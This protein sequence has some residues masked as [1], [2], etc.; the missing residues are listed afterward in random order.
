[1]KCNMNLA[2]VSAFIHMQEQI[3][4][5][6]SWKCS[7]GLLVDTDIFR[8][9]GEVPEG[10]MHITSGCK[11]LASREYMQRHNNL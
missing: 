2:E 8:L 3:V 5:L 11:M 1:M 7:R 10:V 6:G 4:G 9:C